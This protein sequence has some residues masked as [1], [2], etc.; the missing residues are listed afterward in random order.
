MAEYDYK[1]IKKYIQMHSD[2]IDSVTLGMAEDWYWTAE[3]VYEDGSFLTDLDKEPVI[4]GIKGSSWATPTMEVLFKDGSEITKDVYTG[5]VTPEKK[6]EWFELGELS[7][8]CQDIRD[9]K[10]LN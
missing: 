7:Q 9:G 8:S 4:A 10:F 5:K 6:P 3:T 1:N 2:L